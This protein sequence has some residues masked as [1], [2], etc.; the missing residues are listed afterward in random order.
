MNGDAPPDARELPIIAALPS[1]MA[2]LRARNTAVLV[3]PPGAGKTTGVPLALLDAPWRGDGKVL[4]LEP[5]RLAARAAAE[6]MART[7]GENVGQRVGYRVRLESR[8]SAGTRIEVI[9]EGVFT[10]MILEDPGLDG[11]AAVLFDEFHE[12][13]LDADLG[14]ALAR[15]SQSLLRPDLRILI[16]SA[17]LDGARIAA[18]LDD[19]EV[20]ESV[21]RA[22]PVETRY[23]GRDPRVRLETQMAKAIRGALASEAGDILAFLPGQAEIS[24]TE[25]ELLAGPPLPSVD[26]LPLYGALDVADQDRAVAPAGPGRRKVVLAS[27][28]AETS[29][30]LAGVRTVIDSGLAR[31]ACWDP[32]AGLTRLSTHRVSRASAD[33]RRGRAGRTAPGVC[34]RLWDEA[35]T[36]ALPPFDPP[37]ILEADLSR[38]ALDLARWGAAD[39]SELVFLDP[40]PPAA[41]A[42]ARVLLRALEA[43]DS[44]GILTAHGEALS[45]LPLPP[46][47]AH[48]VRLG[49]RSGQGRRA[50]ELTMLLTERGL[51]GA[52]TDI[53]RRAQAFAR[54]EGGRA[55][56]ARALAARWADLAGAPENRQPLTDGL[57][58]A[59][60]FPERV[61]KARGSAG[62][63]QLAS[64]RGAFLEPTDPLAKAPW[65]AVADLGGGT[66]RD[67]ILLAAELD[68][69]DLRAAFPAR[70][71]TE[72]LLETTGGGG[73]RARRLTRL[74]ALVV[75]AMDLETPAPELIAQALMDDVV[76]GGLT[77]LPWGPLARSLRA[78]LDFLRHTDPAWPDVSDEGLLLQR[79]A[80]LAPLLAGRARLGDL[81]DADLAGA[82]RRLLSYSLMARLEAEAPAT[83]TS[84]AGSVHEV[85]FGAEGGPRVD[86]RVQALFGLRSHP[87]I[88]RDIPL[89]LGLL[90][91]AGRP[92]QLT[93]DLPGFWSGSW[94]EVRKEMRGR[95]PKHPWPEDPA[96][97][98]PT[99]RAKP[100]V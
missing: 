5:R 61:A 7:L 76:Q 70:F 44:Q 72:D 11:V 39:A 16:M 31:R 82:L 60:A 22:F 94:R 83:W 50:A 100:R 96:G 29:L 46:R 59:A 4:V 24:R 33:Q 67:R 69:D 75:E 55:K 88:G 56:A 20:I 23:L 68:I 95:Y 10:R 51:G 49:A 58:I 32:G 92:L 13:S 64:G 9:T 19:A 14:L 21:G 79:E 53:S 97:A 26:V 8:I 43:L 40:P 27:A 54:M 87:M 2:A 28:I 84:P 65:L 99:V 62:E 37:E 6:R 78:R 45:R 3:A 90:S 98:T 48:M 18:L 77:I 86:V 66:H 42:E 89:V 38:L 36:R 30:T 17:T 1:L 47:L 74:D 81:T 91:P 73:K 12:R 63:F 85:D 57:L 35:E 80:W 25:A 34:L 93:R 15:N 71:V 52:D 41:L